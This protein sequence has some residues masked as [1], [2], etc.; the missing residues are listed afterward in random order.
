MRY[1]TI[2]DISEY[3]QVYR[4]VNVRLLYMHLVLKSGYHDED[5]DMITTS[6]RRLAADTGL[7]VSAVRFA[8]KV[9][10]S[11]QLLQR[12]GNVYQV[13]KWVIQTKP[14]ARPKNIEEVQEPDAVRQR[15]V[16]EEKIKAER[17]QDQKKIEKFYNQGKTP[18]MVYYEGQVKLAEQGDPH[19]I[20]IVK[21]RR[22]QYESAK[23]YMEEMRKKETK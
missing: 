4:N 10:Q 13:K 18:F 23:A 9:L 6:I 20:E 14:R 16:E 1:T 19:A 21:Q 11:Y 7:T 2:I 5:R 3:P 15:K 12:Q 22:S 17:R 8:L